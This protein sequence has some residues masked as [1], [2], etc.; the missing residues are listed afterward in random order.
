MNKVALALRN[1]VAVIWIWDHL[2]H[3][4]IVLKHSRVGSAGL[5]DALPAT[6]LSQS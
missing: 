2:F 1:S 6:Y 4:W 5:N 3:L